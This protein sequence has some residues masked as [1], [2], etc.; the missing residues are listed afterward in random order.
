MK[1]LAALGTLIAVV[2]A[3]VYLARRKSR[4]TTT[5]RNTRHWGLK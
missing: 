4:E 1:S 2:L 3:L 5:I